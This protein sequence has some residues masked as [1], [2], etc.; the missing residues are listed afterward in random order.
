MKTL[1]KIPYA[2]LLLLIISLPLLLIYSTLFFEKNINNPDQDLVLAPM[3][4]ITTFH[5]YIEQTK[6]Y[7]ILDLQ[8]LRDFSV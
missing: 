7:Q 2:V 8:P 5:D 3:S 1:K 6:N 4:K